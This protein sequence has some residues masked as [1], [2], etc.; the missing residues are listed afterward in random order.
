MLTLSFSLKRNMNVICSSRVQALSGFTPRAL[1]PSIWQPAMEDLIQIHQ[2]TAANPY[3][4]GHT[5][6]VASHD[7]KVGEDLIHMDYMLQ[8][9]PPAWTLCC[10]C[11]MEDEESPLPWMDAYDKEPIF[12]EYEGVCSVCAIDSTRTCKECG[13]GIC[14]VCCPSSSLC[15]AC[16][17]DHLTF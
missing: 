14:D 17:S 3:F 9:T 10:A 6:L 15:H 5:Y 16:I 13:V 7:M 8:W 2:E 12:C 4:E 11:Y 1:H